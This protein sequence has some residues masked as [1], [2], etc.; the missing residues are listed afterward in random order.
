MFDG[1]DELFSPDEAV[2]RHGN[3]ELNAVTALCDSE[4]PLPLYEP[5]RTTI[6]AVDDVT[7]NERRGRMHHEGTRLMLALE[8]FR[9]RA[10]RYPERL[11]DLAPGV[12]AEVPR[13]SYAPDGAFRYRLVDS[14]GSDPAKS[15]LLYSVGLDGEDN[16][17]KE[18]E[19]RVNA[20]AGGPWGRG[21]DYI[22]NSRE[23]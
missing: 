11:E 17:G 5:L 19:N 22:I 7:R 6:P 9:A 2:R 12:L 14:G 13:D 16:G 15:Y 18:A 3:E 23:P 20:L 10:G 8:V 4:K 1:I 21:Y